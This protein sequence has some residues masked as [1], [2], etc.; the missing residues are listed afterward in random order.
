[1]SLIRTLMNCRAGASAQKNS[2][3]RPEM[4]MPLTPNC[5]F[6]SA[7]IRVHLRPIAF[8]NGAPGENPPEK[9]HDRTHLTFPLCLITVRKKKNR[10]PQRHGSA[11][12]FS[13]SESTK[14]LHRTHFIFPLCG[15]RGTAR[16]TTGRAVRP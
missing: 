8:P 5:F 15:R 1:M 16:R 12:I 13:N 7:F 14:N 3:T 4:K 6:L 10:Y 9:M 11:L 2:T